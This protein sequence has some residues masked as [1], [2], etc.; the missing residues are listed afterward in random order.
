MGRA[1]TRPTTWDEELFDHRVTAWT[2]GEPWTAID[3]VPDQLPIS[4]IPAGE[5]GGEIAAEV[6]V[7]IGTGV[8]TDEDVSPSRTAQP[9]CFEISCEFPCGQYYRRPR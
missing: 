8:W 2:V 6:Q 4:V 5:P 1:V 3:G 7:V 9:D